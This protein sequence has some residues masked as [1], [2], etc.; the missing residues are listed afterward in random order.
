MIRNYEGCKHCCCSDCPNEC[1]HCK[2][3]NEGLDGYGYCKIYMDM[4]DEEQLSFC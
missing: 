1:K 4:E 2:E 3:C